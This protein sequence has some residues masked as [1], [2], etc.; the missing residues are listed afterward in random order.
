MRDVYRC[1]SCAKPDPC[2]V[3][4]PDDLPMPTG[5]PCFMGGAMWELVGQDPPPGPDYVARRTTL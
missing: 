5:C 4:Q 2:E 3:I 1:T